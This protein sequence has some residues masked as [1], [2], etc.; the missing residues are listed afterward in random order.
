MTTV[1]TAQ[2]V[3]TVTVKN[4]PFR[5]TLIRTI[6]FNLLMKL[7]TPGFKPFKQ[8]KSYSE[9]FLVKLVWEVIPYHLR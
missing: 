9:D 7:A 6:M 5:T 1:T 2:V 3:E 4:S 8:H